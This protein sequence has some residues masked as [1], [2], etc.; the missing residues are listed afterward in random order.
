MSPD[1]SASQND[2]GCEIARWPGALLGIVVLAL[3][4]LVL[5]G[6]GDAPDPGSMPAQTEVADGGDPAARD[7]DHGSEQVDPDTTDAS[8]DLPDE[9]ASS[10][11]VS[12]AFAA[13]SYEIVPVPLR[14]AEYIQLKIDP[15]GPVGITVGAAMDV[16]GYEHMLD[17]L[18]DSSGYRDNT[19]QAGATE[20]LAGLYPGSFEI[21]PGFS[22]GNDQ[23]FEPRSNAVELGDGLLGF[24]TNVLRASAGTTIYTTDINAS[25]DGINRQL[26]PRDKRLY[27]LI[28]AEDS[29]GEVQLTINRY[30][31]PA[32]I[33]VD[34]EWDEVESWLRQFEGEIADFEELV[35]GASV[36][37]TSEVCPE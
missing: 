18:T 17:Q 37:G 8:T 32:A 6:C 15:V 23:T 29:A 16:D 31:P 14:V 34:P 24:V 22:G 25:W 19:F 10:T 26:V 2:F 12:V 35:N 3:T 36:E 5:A 33:R 11:M 7:V 20:C 30:T 4:G 28:G 9:G 27:L 21:P 13:G 1:G